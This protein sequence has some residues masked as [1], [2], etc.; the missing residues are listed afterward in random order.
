MGCPGW[1]GG[2]GPGQ[3]LLTA[4][5]SKSRC[6]VWRDVFLS[7]HGRRYTVWRRMKGLGTW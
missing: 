2:K 4:Y 7:T 3:R 5:E 6:G 1:R